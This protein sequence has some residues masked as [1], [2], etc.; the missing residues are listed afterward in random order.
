MDRE[1]LLKRIQALP[2]G[3]RVVVKVGEAFC[4]ITG[5]GELQEGYQPDEIPDDEPITS[6]GEFLQLT[7]GVEVFMDLPRK[8]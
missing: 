7:D 5:A 2:P 6:A 3:S 8:K 1:Q 4:D